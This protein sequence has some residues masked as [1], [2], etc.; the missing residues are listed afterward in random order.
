MSYEKQKLI[1]SKKL[2]QAFD[3]ERLD[4]QIETQDELEERLLG[5]IERLNEVLTTV[6]GVY[7]QIQFMKACQNDT[8][9]LKFIDEN[10]LE[11]KTING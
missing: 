1:I 6:Q 4:Y 8:A 11:M 7:N 2:I 5:E 3:L 9:L 10:E